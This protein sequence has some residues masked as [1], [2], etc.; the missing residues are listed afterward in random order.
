MTD[1]VVIYVTPPST[2][3][4]PWRVR[5]DHRPVDERS[6]EAEAIGLAVTY[7]QMIEHAG[8]VALVKVERSDG[9]WETFQT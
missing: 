8:G 3:R 6:T 5:S 2:E 7:V 1:Q 9:T 4:G